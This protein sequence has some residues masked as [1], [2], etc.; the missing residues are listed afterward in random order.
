MGRRKTTDKLAAYT[1]IYEIFL[2]LS[3]MLAP[4]TPFITE[5]IYQNLHTSSMPDSVHLCNYPTVKSDQIDDELEYGMKQIRG[6]VE[7]GRALRSKI[8][9]NVRYPLPEAMLV[10]DKHVEEKI[11]DLLD[12]LVEEVNVK[13]ISFER[14]RINTLIERSNQTLQCLVRG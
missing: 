6:L 14:K 7:V 5:E 13:K 12:L 9:I 2:G 11:K 8:G 4:F 10:C 1:T 3:T